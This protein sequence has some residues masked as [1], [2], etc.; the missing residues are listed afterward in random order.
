MYLQPP[1]DPCRVL[2]LASLLLASS[3]CTVLLYRTPRGEGLGVQ[4]DRQFAAGGVSIGST[5]LFD[6]DGPVGIASVT[7]LA[8]PAAQINFT[9]TARN[10]APGAELY[11]GGEGA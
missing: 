2:F 5:T 7:A 4:G 11:S 1:R 3:C 6:D 8:N 9:G 10:D